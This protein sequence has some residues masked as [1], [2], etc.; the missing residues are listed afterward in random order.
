MTLRSLFK[1]AEKYAVDN[2]PTLVSAF[3]VTG[4][5][6]TAYLTGKATFKAAE[7]I[8]NAETARSFEELKD[9]VPFTKSEKVAMVWKEYIPP[10]LTV[11]FTIGCIVTANSINAS[12]LAGMAAAYKL[13]EKQYDEYKDKVKEKLGL[14]DEKRMRDEINEETVRRNPPSDDV[15]LLATEDEVLFLESWTGRYF[16]SKMHLVKGAEN[17]INRNLIHDNYATLS[18]FY[19]ELG[20]A[21]TQESSEVGWSIENPICLD[22]TTTLADGGT[23]PVIVMEYSN[24]PTP[25]RNYI[26]NNGFAHGSE[27]YLGIH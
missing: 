16:R 19:D 23:R 15:Q 11:V 21:H 10:A 26:K 27:D 25:I 17:V 2:S 8:Q 3:A 13:T 12:R 7:I 18:D 5:L 4:T 20:L 14:Q 6:T 24:L 22:F 9:D 1:T